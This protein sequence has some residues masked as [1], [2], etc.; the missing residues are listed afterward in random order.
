MIKRNRKLIGVSP[1]LHEKI[2]K[3]A[4]QS[5]RSLCGLIEF[6]ITKLAEDKFR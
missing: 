2:K 3:L 5:N 6:S 1:E 4:A